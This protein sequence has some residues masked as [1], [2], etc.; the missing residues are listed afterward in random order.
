[1]GDT[2]LLPRCLLFLPCLPPSLHLLICSCASPLR[3]RR[4]RRLLLLL[5]LLLHYYYHPPSAHPLLRLVLSPEETGGIDAEGHI[6]ILRR[7]LLMSCR[8]SGSGGCC[9]SAWSVHESTLTR[10]LSSHKH[11]R[12]VTS[13]CVCP[14]T[15]LATRVS[16]LAL[17][18][19]AGWVQGE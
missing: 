19:E 4:R 10:H 5:L 7:Q 17:Q 13:S 12:T 18:A 15:C 16:C 14:V 8:V 1:M 6:V 3:R 2:S 9:L 11:L